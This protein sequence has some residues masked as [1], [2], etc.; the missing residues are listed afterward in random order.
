MQI[1]MRPCMDA[2]P[3]MQWMPGRKKTKTNANHKSYCNMHLFG[4]FFVS[5]KF[6][7][8]AQDTIFLTLSMNRGRRPIF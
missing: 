3:S 1:E 5:F 4:V 8:A 7:N 6:D 2:W